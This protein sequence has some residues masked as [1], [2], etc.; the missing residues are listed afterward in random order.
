MDDLEKEWNILKE[1]QAILALDHLKE[2]ARFAQKLW[3]TQT[4]YQSLRADWEQVCEKEARNWQKDLLPCWWHWEKQ[5]QIF[6]PLYGD[7]EEVD[8]ELRKKFNAY[9]ELKI[10][11]KV[12]LHQLYS[13][14]QK[15]LETEIIWDKITYSQ[16]G[17]GDL[18]AALG[19]PVHMLELKHNECIVVA[20]DG[21]TVIINENKFYAPMLELSSAQLQLAPSFSWMSA[22]GAPFIWNQA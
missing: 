10:S 17:F 18:S 1:A 9:D 16:Q 8:H 22:I 12:F 21:L 13:Y 19:Q 3:Q 15:F 5:V 7:C 4:H 20:S 14:N 11:D 6:G 2:S